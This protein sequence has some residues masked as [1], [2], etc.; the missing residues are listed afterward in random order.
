MQSRVA[1]RSG[2]AAA[3]SEALRDEHTLDLFGGAAAR[4]AKPTAKAE[5]ARSAR[6]TARGGERAGEQADLL[7]GFAEDSA[8]HAQR[9]A[10]GRSAADAAGTRTQDAASAGESVSV[11]ANSVESASAD[12]GSGRR[13]TPAVQVF[14][15]ATAQAGID[16]AP[17]AGRTDSRRSSSRRANSKKQAAQRGAHR[18][19]A[20]QGDA[21][22][23]E[24]ARGQTAQVQ[25]EAAHDPTPEH[26]TRQSA[27]DEARSTE[28]PA[29][30]D[31]ANIEPTDSTRADPNQANPEPP[32]PVAT[33]A[34]AVPERRDT[35]A[36]ADTPALAKTPRTSGNATPAAALSSA[37]SGTGGGNVAGVPTQ[38][39]PSAA[40]PTSFPASAS[41]ARERQTAAP[42]T[43]SAPSNAPAALVELDAHL[44]PLADRIRA[45][46]SETVDL[47]RAADAEM[48]R[49]NRLL[50]ALGVVALIAIVALVAQAVQLSRQRDESAAL[51]RRIDRLAAAQATQEATI[52]TLSQRQD[53]LGAQVDRLT[54]RL[55]GAATPVKRSRRGR[56]Y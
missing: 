23:D 27:A 5:N 36:S 4:E 26:P 34:A 25:G 1:A 28:A 54:S 49:V 17:A 24:T 47:R 38:S 22:R 18:G 39:T 46:Q 42:Q 30:P 43:A 21:K 29:A 12:A 14:E 7:S 3:A 6:A 51:Q 13:D 8:A 52:V 2:R 32:S 40:S 50:L 41:P 20:S 55:S 11:P 44:R 53:E 48:R 45:L 33:R 9:E 37:P 56:G 19:S 31:T 10:D 35:G 16:D 15:P